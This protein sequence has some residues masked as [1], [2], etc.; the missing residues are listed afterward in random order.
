MTGARQMITVTITIRKSNNNS[1]ECQGAAYL[2]GRKRNTLY[3]YT[4]KPTMIYQLPTANNHY[5]SYLLGC[6]QDS[7][8]LHF[9]LQVGI[10]SKQLDRICLS[11]KD[12]F[13]HGQCVTFSGASSQSGQGPGWHFRLQA[14]FPQ[15]NFF[16]HTPS[17]E[18]YF[19]AEDSWV[20]KTSR[21]TFPQ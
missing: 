13:P 5:W 20:H 18:K 12:S 3:L 8:L 21:T 1:L 6:P 9:C 7:F 2:S 11:V 16:S 4:I 19:E 17:Q 10:A 15:D 14:W